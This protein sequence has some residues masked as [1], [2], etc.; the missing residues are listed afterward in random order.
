[1]NCEM[2]QRTIALSAL[3]PG[4]SR[5]DAD[6]SHPGSTG[7]AGRASQPGPASPSGPLDQPGSVPTT[8]RAEQGSWIDSP[9][10][11]WSQVEPLADR[12]SLGLAFGEPEGPELEVSE[13]D[14][15]ALE[16]H[17]A[18]C[19]HCQ[20]EMAAT[21]AFYRAL[22][23]AGEPEPTPS[24]LARARLRLDATLDSHAHQSA[25]AHLLQQLSFSAG[26]LRASPGLAS[27]LLLLG[28]AVGG[29]GGYRAGQH[30]HNVDQG[31][32][33]DAASEPKPT[34]ADVISIKRAPDSESVEVQYDRL[35]PDAFSGSLDNPSIRRLLVF[36]TE[37][38]AD[39]TVSTNSLDLLA[40]ECRHG[41]ACTGGPVRNAL[42]RA[43]RSDRR[44]QV[45]LEALEGLEPYIGEDMQVR[46]AV[47]R[48]MLS[49]AS[50]TVR[51][52]AIHVLT[53][54]E[55]D[56]S[57][58]QALHSVASHDGDPSIRTASLEV[59]RAM[60]QLQ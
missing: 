49:D 25:V 47:V 54:V 15:Q 44:P 22:L 2:A 17:L 35:V 29:Y 9:P 7:A 13:E 50:V 8:P 42:L 45:R 14:R 1:M 57:V 27:A 38:G 51:I 24:L 12:E 20:A 3:T 40:N 4:F 10:R 34:I 18:G 41:H 5:E 36:A 43:L 52:E 53:P 30:A 19:R 58:R 26:R 33:I 11:Q 55:V 39:P 6:Y 56:S 37:N 31:L 46:D 28:L 48:A 21:A 23:Q 60:P 16:E 59:L 32:M